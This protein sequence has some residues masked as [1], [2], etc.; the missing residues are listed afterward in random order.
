MS[1]DKELNLMSK[2]ILLPKLSKEFSAIMNEEGVTLADLLTGLT[3]EREAIYQEW[4]GENSGLVQG[5]L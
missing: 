4:Y 5:G 2:E 3:E 1:D